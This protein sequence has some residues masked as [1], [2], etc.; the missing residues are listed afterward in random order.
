MTTTAQS[1]FS[2]IWA[3]GVRARRTSVSRYESTRPDRKAASTSM[4]TRPRACAAD[5]SGEPRYVVGQH[6]QPFAQRASLVVAVDEATENDHTARVSA[7]G[8][9]PGPVGIAEAIFSSENHRH[10]LAHRDPGSLWHDIASRDTSGD[11]DSNVDFPTEG[12]P[13][14]TVSLP[15]GMRSCHQVLDVFPYDAVESDD[16]GLV[17]LSLGLGRNNVVPVVSCNSGKRLELVID[18][19]KRFDVVAMGEV[20]GGVCPSRLDDMNLGHHRLERSEDVVG[21]SMAGRIFV[22]DNNCALAALE[23]RATGR[24]FPAPPTLVVAVSP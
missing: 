19:L 3:R 21:V 15:S 18:D 2:A 14:M 12:S 11:V 10:R 22:G 8:V 9:E 1:S 7:R 16:H 24:H 6:G 13:S 23:G 5:D 17:G 20:V 4:T